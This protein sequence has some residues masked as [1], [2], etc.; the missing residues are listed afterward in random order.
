LLTADPAGLKIASESDGTR[1]S[2]RGRTLRRPSRLYGTAILLFLFC[3]GSAAIGADW[4]TY[5]NDNFRSGLDSNETVLTVSNVNFTT[6]GKIFSHSVDGYVYAQPLVLSA[7]AIPGSGTHNVLFVATEHDSVYAFDADDAAGGNANPLWQVSFL[8]NPRPGVTVTTVPSADVNSGDLV[9]EIGITSTPVIDPATGTIYVEA[10]TKEVIVSPP[11]ASYLHRLHAL[12]V[13]TGAEKFG[14]PI[15]INAV[16]AGTGDGSV[17]HQVSF[18]G[19][20][21]M[22]RPGLLLSNGVVYLGYASHGDNGPYHGWVF[23]YDA[24]SLAPTGVYNTTPD[25]GLGGIWMAGDGLAADASG[26]IYYSTG[27]GTYD[28]STPHPNYGDSVTKLSGA[29]GFPIPVL[30]Y[31]TPFNQDQLNSLDW[32]LG[33]GG[34]LLLPDQPGPNP[35]LLVTAGKEG[36]IYLISRDQLG[37]YDPNLDHCVQTL[38][39]AVGGG[40][41][42]GSWSTPAYF[43]GYVYY[44]ANDDFIKA[45]QMT[46]GLLSSSPTSESTN[47]FNYPGPSP[48]VSANG[49]SNGIV[50]TIQNQNP[51]VLYAYDASNLA[52][53]LYD[54]NQAAGGRDHPGP[55][56]KFTVPAIANGKVYVGTQQGVSAFG[57]I[58]CLAGAPTAGN[59]GPLCA[60]QDLQLTCSPV[61]G[62]TYS[63]TGP[64]GFASTL[65]SPT[66]PAVTVADAGDYTVT[67][68]VAGCPPASATTTVAVSASPAPVISTALCAPPSTSGLTASVPAVAGDLYTWSLSGG[69]IDSGNGTAAISFTS[70]GPGSLMSLSLVE[71]NAACSGSASSP[72]QVS[73]TDV[74]ASNPF[75]GFICTI[76]RNGI[77]AGC[78][79]GNFCP[80][81]NVLRAQMAV[82]LLRGEHGSS[83]VAPLPN[84]IFSDVSINDPFA[85]WIEELYNEGITGGCS[86]NPLMYCPSNPVSRAGMAVFLLVAEHG[87]GYAPPACAG[88]FTD[89]ACPG[90]FTNWIEQLYNEGITGGC[91]T[92][93]LMYCPG[94]PVTRGQMAVFLTATFNLP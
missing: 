86:T 77:T 91:N 33:S 30:D 18:N 38:P 14:G 83:Y 67:A 40:S 24:A 31:F 48:V 23:G 45:F 72:I 9:P 58:N 1:K 4:L 47:T 44:G 87:T 92:N 59:N 35:H 60:G 39:N 79:S 37:G 88:I 94:N 56:V 78:G 42:D 84:G 32:D 2:E 8:A 46:N 27:N 15:L 3:R 90:A 85:P 19:L 6:F 69:T 21:Q 57:L 28:L 7:V 12:D 61:S 74:P 52:V 65:Q 43:N 34:V 68:T 51:A 22:N 71:A 54:S 89:V 73:F 11:S 36:K 82:F 16:V 55:A 50:W 17:N 10:K 66:I 5:R 41:G 49:A 63:W 25:G 26:N 81:N 29:G 93:P 53:M 76:A 62:A 75:A 80:A 13:A 64:N 20:R 70:G